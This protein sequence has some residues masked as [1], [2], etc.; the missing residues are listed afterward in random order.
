MSK[1]GEEEAAIRSGMRQVEDESP[2][3][4]VGGR[5]VPAWRVPGTSWRKK[6]DAARE[7]YRRLRGIMPLRR[8]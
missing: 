3:L 8:G 7:V 6:H 4:D 1:I 5:E 2:I